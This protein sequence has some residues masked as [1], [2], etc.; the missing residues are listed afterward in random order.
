MSDNAFSTR[1]VGLAAVRLISVA[2][3]FLTGVIAARLLGADGV[4]TAGIA[5]VLANVAAVLCNGGVNISTIYLLG[6]HPAHGRDLVAGLIPIAVAGAL[7]AAVLL[8]LL[9][10]TIAP[11]IGLEGRTDLVLAAAA[12]GAAIVILEFVGAVLLGGGQD[13]GYTEVELLRG[14]GTL[15]TTMLLLAVWQSDLSFVLAAIMAQGI[16][17]VFAARGISRHLGTP[18]PRL[19]PALAGSAIGIGLRGQIGNILQFLN[20]RLDQLMVPMFLS[21]SSAG[22]YLIAVRVA[23]A[24]AQLGSAVGSLI[25][26]EV[27]RGADASSTL[28]ERAVRVT[29]ITTAGAGLLLGLVADA[30]LSLAFGSGFADGTVA[31]R[32]LLIA[33]VPLSMVRVLAGDLKGR[34]R[35]G[36]VSVAMGLAVVVNVLLNLVLIPQFGIDGAAAASV[37]TYCVA[38][39]ALAAAFTRITG[40]SAGALVPRPSDVG[41]IARFVGGM[42]AGAAR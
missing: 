37:I 34:G 19:D 21:I 33:M 14:I 42:I 5:V 16:A 41:T 13:R 25:F 39:I 6:R 8:A 17:I 12:L 11:F 28:T 38:A 24:L 35:P 10:N 32:I 9:G 40:A 30:F 18:A 1:V 36:T 2:A 15:A 26:P 31:L 7:L 27:A 23:E 3:G 20:L 4:G 29:A 22:V